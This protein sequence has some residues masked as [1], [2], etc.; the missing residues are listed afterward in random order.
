MTPDRVTCPLHSDMERH[1]DERR[2]QQEH[3]NDTVFH[4]LDALRE[5]AEANRVEAIQAVTTISVRVAKIV[6]I[7]LVVQLVAAAGIAT[8]LAK[9][10]K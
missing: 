7:G 10:L 9:L 8:A 2:V 1:C 4:L 6:G 3:V 5:R